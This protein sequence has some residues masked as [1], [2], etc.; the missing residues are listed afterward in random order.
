MLDLIFSAYE[1]LE[2][3]QD[4]ITPLQFGQLLLDWTDGS[5]VVGAD[6]QNMSP[7]HVNLAVDIV[8]ALYNNEKPGKSVIRYRI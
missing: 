1:D 2:D 8:R 5:K 6:E 7:V 4:M 3:D